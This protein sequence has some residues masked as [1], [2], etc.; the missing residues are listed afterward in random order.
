MLYGIFNHMAA[1]L[2]FRAKY[3]YPDGAVREMVLWKLPE[4]RP[5]SSHIFKYRLYYGL[6]DGTCL[7]RY[8]N[9]TAKGDHRHIADREARYRFRDVETLVEDF[10]KDIADVRGEKD[11]EKE[12]TN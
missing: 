11:N 5:G 2:I 9:E 4:K 3:I 1:A 6:T 7:V 8:D 12:H 10:L